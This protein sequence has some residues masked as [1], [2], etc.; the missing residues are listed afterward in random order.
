MWKLTKGFL[1]TLYKLKNK[2]LV[3]NAYCPICKQDEESVTHLFRD[4]K[5]TKKILQELG[6][7]DSTT[8][9]NQNW[10]NWLLD[11]FKNDNIKCKKLVVSFWALWFNRNRVYHEGLTPNK[12]KVISFIKAYI[13]ENELFEGSLALKPVPKN[14]KREPP[15][16]DMIRIN[17][18]A[19]FQKD[20]NKSKAGIIVRNKDGLTMAA[21][22]YQCKNILT[23][24]MAEAWA[25][26]HAVI[27]RE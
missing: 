9:T 24:E 3:R 7:N 25:C 27:F 5:F 20:L 15:D 13:L 11:F 8:D 18:D 14:V 19:S 23:P 10:Q 26:L 4:C 16:G 1:P 22:S 17:F 21:C 12:Q 2:G 6:V